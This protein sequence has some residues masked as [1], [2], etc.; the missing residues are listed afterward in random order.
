MCTNTKFFFDTVVNNT[1]SNS[2]NN[3]NIFY[4]SDSFQLFTLSLSLYIY[5]FLYIY[6]LLIYLYI[7]IQAAFF[8][9]LFKYICTRSY[10]LPLRVIYLFAFV[11]KILSVLMFKNKIKLE[12]YV[13]LRK[14]KLFSINYY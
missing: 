11:A 12:Y 14:S 9:C 10:V 13:L 2:Q 3:I 4:L 6:I 1:L 8:Q 7:Y 5:I